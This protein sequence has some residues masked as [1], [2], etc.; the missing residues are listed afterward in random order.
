[1]T[2][3]KIRC[4]I[5]VDKEK[6]IGQQLIEKWESTKLEA[7]DIVIGSTANTSG[8]T[9]V[10]FNRFRSH[11]LKAINRPESPIFKLERR[12]GIK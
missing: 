4:G 8:R 12:M 7:I 3:L 1:M 5:M 11:K 10:W 6:S 2:L 9:I